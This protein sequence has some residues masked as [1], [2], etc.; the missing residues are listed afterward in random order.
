MAAMLKALAVSGL[1]RLAEPGEFARRAFEHGKLVTVLNKDWTVGFFPGSL[2]YLFEATG[3]AKWRAAAARYTSL[4][5]NNFIDV[6]AYAH[7][8][9]LGLFPSAPCTDADPPGG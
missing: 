6:Q 1:A 3:E 5:T 2:W 9:K 7:F 4:P 8:Q